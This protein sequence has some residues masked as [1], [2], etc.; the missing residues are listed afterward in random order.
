MRRR[1]GARSDLTRLRPLPLIATGLLMAA[2]FVCVLIL[3]ALAASGG[4]AT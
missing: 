2:G 4:L 3:A 1:A